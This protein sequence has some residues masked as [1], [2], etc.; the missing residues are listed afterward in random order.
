M[1]T[2]LALMSKS[3]ADKPLDLWKLEYF[4]PFYYKDGVRKW[5]VSSS[6]K[7]NT[8]II[9]F[10]SDGVIVDIRYALYSV[11]KQLINTLRM[12]SVLNQP[13]V[14]TVA[15]VRTNKANVI[16]LYEFYK[17]QIAL[18]EQK[19]SVA[20]KIFALLQKKNVE[21]QDAINLLDFKQPF[22]DHAAEARKC[23]F[24][25]SHYSHISGIYV[26][27]VDRS[28]IYYIG[29]ATNWYSR[30]YAHFQKNSGR[31]FRRPDKELAKFNHL[32][33]MYKTVEVACIDVP[34]L[35]KQKQGRR[36]EYVERSQ[37]EIAM[38]L[39]DLERE[40]TILFKPI[41]VDPVQTDSS[42]YLDIVKQEPFVFT[43]PSNEPA[44]F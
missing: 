3:K 26:V 1:K 40:L 5:N 27:L 23:I 34:M 18:Y 29:K 28:S 22:V 24:E 36:T 37:S 32:F 6:N 7:Q 10:R 11:Y 33:G 43:P 25:R 4:A 9:I 8:G 17:R 41:H 39:I 16:Q 35:I 13:H 12:R 20:T 30:M 15:V 2:A 14:D 19:E 31:D 42:G 38:D 44:P 21:P